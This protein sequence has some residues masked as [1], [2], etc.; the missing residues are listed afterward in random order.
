MILTGSCGSAVMTSM[1]CFYE[2]SAPSR[3]LWQAL[4]KERDRDEDL[5]LLKRNLKERLLPVINQ[6][7]VEEIKKAYSI[8]ER[9][10]NY[11]LNP[12]TKALKD[13][14]DSMS[15]LPSYMEEKAPV[16]PFLGRHPKLR[17]VGIEFIFGLVSFVAYYIGTNF[18]NISSEDTY[19]LACTIWVSLTVGYWAIGKRKS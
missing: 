7:G 14:N 15:E 19:P 18:L 12:T 10:A 5:R 9:F 11:L 17:Y 1:F 6:G 16:I 4:S 8:T 2:P 13:L 3:S